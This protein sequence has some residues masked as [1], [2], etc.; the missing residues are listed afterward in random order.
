MLLWPKLRS[1]RSRQ[2]LKRCAMGAMRHWP[3]TMNKN[4]PKHAPS[5]HGCADNDPPGRIGQIDRQNRNETPT[6]IR[7][8][9]FIAA[10]GI[11]CLPSL[12]PAYA[13][14]RAD[15]GGIAIGG[16]VTGSTIN[17]GGPPEQLA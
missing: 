4:S 5:S 6:M 1:A 9:T 16:N 7:Y 8:L 11:C 10:L 12:N 13:Q 17:I 2:R 3:P 15:S 14:V